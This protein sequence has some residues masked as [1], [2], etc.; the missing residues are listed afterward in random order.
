MFMVYTYMRNSIV[1]ILLGLVLC[2]LF[3]LSAYS[4]T[5]IDS[6]VTIN[7]TCGMDNGV[8]II[9]ASDTV[10][11]RYSIDNGTTYQEEPRF[12]NVSE[13]DYL[14]VILQ[15]TTCS[16]VNTT[17]LVNDPNPALPILTCPDDLEIEC[18]NPEPISIIESWIME[19]VAIDFK[20]D[21]LPSSTPID[22]STLDFSICGS[23]IPLDIEAIDGCQGTSSCIATINI[24]DTEDPIISCPQPLPI[25]LADLSFPEIVEAWLESVDGV[26]NC[27][28]FSFNNDLDESRI[29]L[30]CDSFYT[31]SVL[32]TLEDFCSNQDTCRSEIMVTN[33]L[34][35]DIICTDD[36]QVSCDA[37]PEDSLDELLVQFEDLNAFDEDVSIEDSNIEDLVGLQ[38]GDTLTLVYLVIDGCLRQSNCTSLI[39][40]LDD[41]SPTLISCP[42]LLLIDEVNDQTI[43]DIE[44]WLTGMEAED[45]CAMIQYE[46]DF[47]VNVFDDLCNV[48]DTL[49]IIFSA[50]DGCGNTTTCESKLYIAPQSVEVTCPD[51]LVLSCGSSNNQQ[52]TDDWINSATAIDAGGNSI[53]YETEI[54][55]SQGT[56]CDSVA[57][58]KVFVL[59]NCGTEKSCI[60][61][62]V[63]VDELSPELSC[64]DPLSVE[65]SDADIT[66][67]V[68]AWLDQISATDLCT[69]PTINYSYQLDLPPNTCT[70]DTLIEVSA[71]DN[72]SNESNCTISFSVT[73]NN[74][75]SII[76]PQDT[77]FACSS[78]DLLLSVDNY[79]ESVSVTANAGFDLIND[80]DPTIIDDE[81]VTAQTLTVTITAIDFCNNANSCFTTFQLLPDG[82]LYIPDVFSLS[83][84]GADNTFTIFGNGGIR[85]I[86]EA[87]VYDRWGNIIN[88]VSGEMNESSL[89]IWDGRID[90]KVA[91]S[92]VYLYKIKYTDIFDEKVEKT[93][94]ITLLK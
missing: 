31:I 44:S 10:N 16:D 57:A 29:N 59:D 9:Y 38:C 55:A 14:V 46:T 12:N 80:F 47:D 35:P 83:A 26:D 67:Q 82:K 8:I 77:V 74:F 65:A 58:V 3:S 90:N 24:I 81:C 66:E 53:N 34:Q 50:S 43:P 23:N 70:L 4:A 15:G 72:C 63:T 91:T 78:S 11:V 48:P 88:T 93:G 45:N 40:I 33:E 1:Q 20:T 73:N 75:L 25:D 28:D 84:V 42:S 62:I 5:V 41:G 89:V 19:T 64:P 30:Q 32:F 52:L 56:T 76:C 71:I 2:I 13:G 68:V 79:L 6:I 85:L 51:T 69:E 39:T 87:T 92:G 27:D 18:S 61:T 21:S 7:S 36:F 60:T 22:L 94:Q 37:D 49:A 54:D 17:V 86:E